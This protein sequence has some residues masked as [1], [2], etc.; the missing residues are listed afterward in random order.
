MR[1]VLLAALLALAP[2][3]VPPSPAAAQS[4]GSCRIDSECT[5]VDVCGCSCHAEL[6]RALPPME[7]SAACDGT[8]CAGHR[9]VCDAGVC[10]MR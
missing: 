7:C 3:C 2:G 9:A 10:V 1:L 6:G 5:L 8:P 4:T